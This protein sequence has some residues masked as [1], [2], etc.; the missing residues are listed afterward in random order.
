V[1]C[2]LALCDED[3]RG[4]STHFLCDTHA[5]V[6]VEQ[7]WAQVYSTAD[8]LQAEL[9]RKNLVAE[10]LDARVLSQ[11]DHSSLPVN[12]GDLSPVRVLVPAF[13]YTEATRDITQHMDNAGEVQFGD[14]TEETPPAA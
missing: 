7:G 4:G 14:N 1:V 10:G 8:D 12:L 13:S 3:N 9:I 5:T 11:K 2:G 6:P